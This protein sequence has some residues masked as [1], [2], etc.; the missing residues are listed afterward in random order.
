VEAAR[1]SP[2][3]EGWR[4]AQSGKDLAELIKNF[5]MKLDPFKIVESW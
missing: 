2:C 3:P 5:S 4:C 1:F